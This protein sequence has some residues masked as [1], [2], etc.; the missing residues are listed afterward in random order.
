MSNRNHDSLR[1]GSVATTMWV[2]ALTSVVFVAC[3]DDETNTENPE[4]NGTQTFS[5][6]AIQKT[7]GPFCAGV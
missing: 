3:G 1:P 6:C 5:I 7:A 4:G 2:L